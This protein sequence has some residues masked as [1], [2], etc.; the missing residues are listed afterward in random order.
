VYKRQA[1]PGSW[2]IFIGSIENEE[3]F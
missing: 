2:P 1:V 3:C